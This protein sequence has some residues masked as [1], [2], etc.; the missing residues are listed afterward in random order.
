[1]TISE[2]FRGYTCSLLREGIRKPDLIP[3]WRNSAQ[4]AKEFDSATRPECLPVDFA[5]LYKIL[6]I[7]TLETM[8]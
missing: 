8:Q 1:M 7:E 4:L 5:E 3:K 6:F 2:S